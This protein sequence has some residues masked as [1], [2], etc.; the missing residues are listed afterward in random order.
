MSLLKLLQREGLVLASSNAHKREEFERILSPLGIRVS[1]PGE[2]GLK[3]D[4]EETEHTF[5][6]NAR[7]K[8]LWLAERLHKPVLADDSGLEVDALGGE[9]GVMSA[10]Y[11]GEGLSDQDR[12]RLVL[13]RL[14][15]VP[16]ERRTARFV[17]VLVLVPGE[18]EQ[19][20]YSFRGTAEGVILE[21]MRGEQGFG[22]DPIFLDPASGLTFA[23]MEG[24]R[25]DSLSHRGRAV[26]QFLDSL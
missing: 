15:G 26:Q 14:Q 25:K 11:G 20:S 4:V 2:Y 10:R 19:E 5:E 23:E 13:E 17:S 7:L 12:S 21:E 1:T 6:G 3:L 24:S 16:E 18:G 22:Y 9:P 8:A